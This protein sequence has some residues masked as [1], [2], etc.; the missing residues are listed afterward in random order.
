MPR[1]TA[2]RAIWGRH[3][4]AYS[5]VHPN[6]LR[7]TLLKLVGQLL[8]SVHEALETLRRSVQP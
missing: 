3:A 1:A 6:S 7:Q 2:M 8:V 5:L 4:L